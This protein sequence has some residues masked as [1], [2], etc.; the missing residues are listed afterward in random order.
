MNNNVTVTHS[1]HEP[2]AR[3][4][5][6]WFDF[7]EGGKPEYPEKNLEVKE[8]STAGILLRETVH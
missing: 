7:R 4:S 8:R 3:E 5:H 6:I 2:N 1:G